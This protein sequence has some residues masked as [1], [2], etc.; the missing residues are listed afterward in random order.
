M[1]SKPK[2][3]VVQFLM[4]EVF[5]KENFLS[6]W[7]VE[8]EKN[9]KKSLLLFFA[10]LFVDVDSF[11]ISKYYGKK[12]DLVS[13]EVVESIFDTEKYLFS[14]QQMNE[15][16]P[17]V[18]L[19]ENFV[20][21][22]MFTRFCCHVIYREDFGDQHNDDFWKI[23]SEIKKSAVTVPT[24]LQVKEI[25][26][27]LF[28]TEKSV[29]GQNNYTKVRS[30]GDGVA[31][32][33]TF[34]PDSVFDVMRDI[35][36]QLKSKDVSKIEKALSF[37]HVLLLSGPDAVLSL[38]LDVIEIIRYFLHHRLSLIASSGVGLTDA[39]LI[40]TSQRIISTS[41]AVLHL[42]LDLQRLKEQGKWT[43]LQRLGAFPHMRYRPKKKHRIFS[44]V[45]E[46]STS[47]RNLH[48]D[49]IFSR[50]YCL[51]HQVPESYCSK[52]R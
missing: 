33:D 7:S 6:M 19:L 4:D 46:F 27:I 25:I 32:R 26:K 22:Q 28:E 3:T 38:S 2:E 39:T 40:L 16:T 41:K 9:V 51:I 47:L 11:L 20:R 34:Q 1:T 13:E 8:A 23:L 31:Y 29:P 15:T 42:L 17:V 52:Q 10:Y 45:K 44:C 36:C 30:L 43:R 24:I 37:L 50:F 49:V 12:Y 21:S 35:F 18:R 48:E 5:H 14:K